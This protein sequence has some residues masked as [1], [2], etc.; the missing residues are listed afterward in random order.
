MRFANTDAACKG[1]LGL[2]IQPEVGE[3]G[4][5]RKIMNNS[6]LP[7]Y[8]WGEAQAVVGRWQHLG[9]TSN[10]G[11]HFLPKLLV[12]WPH[13]WNHTER[14][15]FVLAE[16]TFRHIIETQNSKYEPLG[17]HV[18]WQSCWF[19]PLSGT[20]HWSRLQLSHQEVSGFTMNVIKL[21]LWGTSK[22]VC[23]ILYSHSFSW[24]R[25]LK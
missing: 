24:R 14:S 2:G 13:L 11:P 3:W 20:R 25:L 21:N 22:A 9:W 15:C 19:I 17:L 18:S 8:W 16:C 10:Q 1:S 4:M 5:G 23:L 7:V 6:G 12:P